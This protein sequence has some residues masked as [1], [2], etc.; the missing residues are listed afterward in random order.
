M[1]KAKT[2]VLE[3]ANTDFAIEP[4]PQDKFTATTRSEA[5]AIGG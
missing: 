3:I 1:S 4:L 2:T 5:P